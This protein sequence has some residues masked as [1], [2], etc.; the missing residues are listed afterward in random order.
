[1][2]PA[3]QRPHNHITAGI[4]VA[5]KEASTDKFKKYAK[6][7]VKNAKVLSKALKRKGYV[8]VGGITENHLI[9]LNLSATNGVGSG[10]FAQE[11][12]SKAGITVNK[13]TVPS[14]SST[15]FYPSGIRLGTPAITSRGMG[16]EEMEKIADL[17]SRALVFVQ[18]ASLPQ[19]K[20]QR[21]LFI[22][23]FKKEISKNKELKNI[24]IEVKK[25]CKKFPI[26]T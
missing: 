21:K 5:L 8:P 4:A 13:N 11:V 3:L 6:Q 17:I 12:L 26:R 15:P 14:E 24:S 16:A 1:L 22:E 7:V 19:D 23:K 20:T 18:V 9:L 10:Y 25:L 2:H